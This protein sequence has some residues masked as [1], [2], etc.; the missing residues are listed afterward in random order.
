V[1]NTEM[2]TILPELCLS[3]AAEEMIMPSLNRL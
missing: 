1:K 2:P 3:K